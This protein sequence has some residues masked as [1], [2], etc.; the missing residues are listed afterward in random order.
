MKNLGIDTNVPITSGWQPPHVPETVRQVA[1]QDH[2]TFV[3]RY[4]KNPR[5]GG[6]TKLEAELI[7]RKRLFIVSVFEE[8]PTSPAYFSMMQGRQDGRLAAMRAAD[9]RQPKLTP[10]YLTVD[11]DASP[12][13][14]P[15]IRNYFRKAY[16]ELVAS[17]YLLG[18]YGSDLVCQDLAA[19][20]RYAF[21]YEPYLWLSMSAGWERAGRSSYPYALKQLAMGSTDAYDFDVSDTH[22]GGWMPAPAGG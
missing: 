9:C 21:N 7:A 13:D 18:V 22:A 6:L 17:E 11:Y 19:F 15:A 3:A 16:V 1:G 5:R 12:S 10:V 2:I 20:F 14:L 8:N 4:L